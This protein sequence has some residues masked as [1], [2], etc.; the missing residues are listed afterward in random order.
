MNQAINSPSLVTLTINDLPQ[1][2]D[3]YKITTDP[4]LKNSTWLQYK[5]LRNRVNNRKVSDE[6]NYKSELLKENSSCATKTW[7]TVKSL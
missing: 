6:Y 5:K 7:S 2:I 1:P 3:N 4:D